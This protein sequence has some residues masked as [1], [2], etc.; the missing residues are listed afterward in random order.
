MTL[1]VVAGMDST[2]NTHLNT[3]VGDVATRDL[4]RLERCGSGAIGQYRKVELSRGRVR[5]DA[6]CMSG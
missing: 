6:A 4:A 3:P 2:K 1:R 5:R